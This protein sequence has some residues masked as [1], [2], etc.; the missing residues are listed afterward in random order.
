MK[1]S[2]D[3][4]NRAV[5]LAGR[6]FGRLTVLERDGLTAE[7][8]AKWRCACEC[9]AVKTVPAKSLLAGD[10]QSCGCLRKERAAEATRRELRRRMGTRPEPTAAR[11]AFGPTCAAVARTRTLIRSASMGAG[12]YGCVSVGTT[13]RHFWPTWGQPLTARALIALTTTAITSPGTA[14]G[15][16]RWSSATT[17]GA[18]G[19]WCGAVSPTRKRNWRAK[20]A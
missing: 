10:T 15:R 19:Y 8:G 11:T 9:G 2:L 17:P 6:V 18:T 20:S 16:H 7:R 13:S 14:G 4:K 1:S 5:D 3:K 12:G